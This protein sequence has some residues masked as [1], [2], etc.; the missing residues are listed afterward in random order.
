MKLV[1]RFWK[2]SLFLAL[3]VLIIP[4]VFFLVLEFG[5][6]WAGVGYSTRLFLD[7]PANPGMVVRNPD[8]TSPYFGRAVARKLFPFRISKIPA[9]DTFRI[10]VLGGSAAQGDPMPAFP[11]RECLN[12]PCT[13]PFR[14]NGLSVSIW[15]LPRSTHMW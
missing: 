3:L 14:N 10:V 6:R 5:L 7:D 2:P 8:Y 11:R 9:G 13:P 15:P 12:A 1:E 4:S